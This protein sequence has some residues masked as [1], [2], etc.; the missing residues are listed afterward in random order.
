MRG[1]GVSAWCPDYDHADVVDHIT[2][3]TEGKVDKDDD[4]FLAYVDKRGREHYEMLEFLKDY[5]R[6]TKQ[7]QGR[8]KPEL[9][10]FVR[11]MHDEITEL[12][13]DIGALSDD[14]A[15]PVE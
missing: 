12:L 15:Y 2:L 5:R 14:E 11:D 8:S 9:D 7:R 4:D 10:M 3:V 13:H 1:V 6:Y